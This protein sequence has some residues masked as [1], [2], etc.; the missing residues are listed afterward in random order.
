MET[1]LI[2][3]GRM[4]IRIAQNLTRRDVKAYC[5]DIDERAMAKARN[6][7]LR[8]AKTPH[9]ALSRL[10]QPR[11]G[12]LIVPA[13]RAVDDAISASLPRLNPGDVLVDCGNSFY[14]DSIRRARELKRKGIGYLDAGTSGGLEGA[15]NGVSMTVGGERKY[16]G[17]AEPI[18][19]E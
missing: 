13:G 18:L 3:L 17:I 5:Y 8:V 7:G 12:L 15:M 1:A 6:I 10:R 9:I 16:F 2:G 4:G 19:E 14:R 11:I